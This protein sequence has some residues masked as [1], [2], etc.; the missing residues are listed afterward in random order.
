MAQPV[1]AGKET[2]ENSQNQHWLFFQQGL[3]SDH[4][5]LMPSK[6]SQRLTVMAMLLLAWKTGEAGGVLFSHLIGS[7]PTTKQ[8]FHII[9][10]G[11]SA[12]SCIKDI[13]YRPTGEP[14]VLCQMHSYKQCS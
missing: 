9:F 3:I 14:V 7:T 5:Y 4:R 2:A 10:P 11:R 12:A 6:F 13:F 8:C 1:R